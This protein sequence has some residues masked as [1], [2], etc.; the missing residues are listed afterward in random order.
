MIDIGR[1]CVK[2][3]GRDAG[4]T[5]VVVDLLDNSKVLIDG[6]TRRRKSNVKHLEPLESTI[7]IKKGATHAD[8]AKELK[9]IGVE[10]RETKSKK[11]A[12]K[13]KKQRGKKKTAEK[14]EDKEPEKKQV[15]K[16]EKKPE[17]KQEEKAEGKKDAKSDSNEKKA[18]KKT[19][20]KKS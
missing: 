18:E 19:P 9:K 14:A 6:D 4:K 2:I 17:A 8:V 16:G 15:K 12:E 13:P 10:S 7:K 5:C 20:S 3:A 1:V 11:S